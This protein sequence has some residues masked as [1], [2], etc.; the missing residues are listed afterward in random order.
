MKEI[1]SKLLSDALKE[2]LI[3]AKKDHDEESPYS[4]SWLYNHK[5]YPCISYFDN[6]LPNFR[7]S[8]MEKKNYTKDFGKDLKFTNI[9]S[10]KKFHEFVLSTPLI[11]KHF[12][13]GSYTPEGRKD[14]SVEEIWNMIY[15][16]FFL[17]HFVDSYIHKHS[18]LY[19]ETFA[20]EMIDNYYNS[21]SLEDLPISIM[22]PLLFTSFSFDCYDL[23][24]NISI[25]KMSTSIQLSRNI[26]NSYISSVHPQVIGAATHCL[27]LKNWTI[28]N[29][30]QE[31]R[32][33]S[34]ND[35]SAFNEA[36]QIAKRFFAALRI[37]KPNIETG[38]AQVV[39]IPIAWQ[40]QY[41]VDIEQ[42]Y[43][44]SE[45][46]YPPYFENYGWL[47]K[48][49]L[50]IDKD[51]DKIKECFI[52]LSNSSYLN[53]AYNRLNKASLISREDDSIIDICI[54]LEA[55]LS[56]DT[57]TEIT[58]RLST[59]ACLLNKLLPFKHY[60]SENIFQLCKRIYD[61]R[62]SVVHGNE[63]KQKQNR[64]IKI[65]DE[66]EIPIVNISIEF[67]KHIIWTLILN[68]DIKTPG[69][70]DKLLFYTPPI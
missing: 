9:E 26:K 51:A 5:D 13:I 66:Q 17:D 57:K 59:R 4:L 20:N 39:A 60:S 50:L 64:T 33:N 70:I 46:N 27:E 32:N 16:Y 21:I 42:T 1:F 56:S 3:L 22:I 24:P 47:N 15:T 34:L 38:F 52:A 30:T 8:D 11:C 18:F 29:T 69:D 68:P 35:I 6:G 2:G 25:K 62:S 54:A 14:E 23:M 49:D 53:L 31:F 44:V 19:E 48:L 45:K 43:V 40:S 58:Y 63:K 12:Q 28:K 41:F 55:L 61:Y 10:W 36:I 7:L 67:L 37:T 65:L